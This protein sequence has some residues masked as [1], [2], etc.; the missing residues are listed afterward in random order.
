[1]IDDTYTAETEESAD[2]SY[3]RAD[4]WV[5]AHLKE[6]PTNVARSRTLEGA[7]LQLLLHKYRLTHFETK[8]PERLGDNIPGL[9]KIREREEAAE[10]V[11]HAPSEE[12]VTA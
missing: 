5:F 2:I 6:D 11:T 1:M 7:A 12:L 9:K 10:K 3:Y 8:V 4:G